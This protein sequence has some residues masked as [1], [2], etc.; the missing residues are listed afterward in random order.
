MLYFSDILKGN[1]MVENV[2]TALP[3]RTTRLPQTFVLVQRPTH[4][5]RSMTSID[6]AYSIIVL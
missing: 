2:L 4:V 6:N 1:G 3:Q 5:G